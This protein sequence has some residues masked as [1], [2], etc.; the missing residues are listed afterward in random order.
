RRLSW[1]R[2]RQPIYC[3][4]RAKK[5]PTESRHWMIFMHP[6]SID[7]ILLGFTRGEHWRKLF[8]AP[9]DDVKHGDPNFEIGQSEISYPKSE[10]ANWTASRCNGIFRIS[11]L[12]STS[13]N[14]P[15]SCED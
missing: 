8:N 9:V 2:N 3:D 12:S 6:R 1:D 4:P 14:F 10:I 13:S 7:W 11:D 15:I 5:R